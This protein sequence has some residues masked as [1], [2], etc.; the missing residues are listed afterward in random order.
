MIYQQSQRQKKEAVAARVKEHKARSRKDIICVRAYVPKI[1]ATQIKSLS[2]KFGICQ[3]K[4][5]LEEER[6]WVFGTFIV[7]GFHP[8]CDRAL[9]KF[10]EAMSNQLLDDMPL[11]TMQV[12]C[13]K[14]SR[15]SKILR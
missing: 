5:L 15:E 9:Q 13:E 8:N 2:D 4:K 11:M 12:D 6:R 14:L 3:T 10:C 7:M 1:V